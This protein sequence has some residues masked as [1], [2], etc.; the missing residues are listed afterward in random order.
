ML[1]LTYT[2]IATIILI[3]VLAQTLMEVSSLPE[4]DKISSLP[5]QPFVNFQQYSGYIAV[6]D[7][8]QRALFYYFVEAEV[9]PASKP[10]VL[11]L[12]GG[13]GCSSVGV[14]GFIEHGPFAPG[15]NGLLRNDYSWNR[16][17]NVLYL[18]SPAGVGF[19][20]SS[21][22]SFYNLVT[23]EITAWDN[24][25]FLQRWFTEFPEYSNNEFFITGESYAGHYVPQLAK[26]IVETKTKINL[27]G[28]AIGNPL[29]E[30]N[31]DFNS[32]A[33]FLWSHGL[34]S[35]SVFGVLNYACSFSQI[36]R[37][38]QINNNLGGVCERVYKLLLNEV[39]NY[40]DYYDVT[41]DVCL[42]SVGQ[43]A[44]VLNQLVNDFL[45]F[46]TLA[47][48]AENKSLKVDVFH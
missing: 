27:K 9:D 35:D 3:V 11:W 2:K 26:L 17:A 15:E 38:L 19:S 14:G 41:L 34:I 39:S 5:G 29:L 47:L 6:D 23:D 30:F 37:E 42:S 44:Y 25:V 16:E 4:Y 40:I 28:I 43:Q 46:L 36:R 45:V 13:P 10:L 7:Q 24:L 48:R 20:Y 21:N 18:E 33:E 8:Q 32:T 22:K 12:N 1:P 31:T